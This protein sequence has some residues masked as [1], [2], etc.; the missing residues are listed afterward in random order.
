MN[1]AVE[2]AKKA[3]RSAS[4]NLVPGKDLFDP[5]WEA[6]LTSAGIKTAEIE[7][8]RDDWKLQWK[9]QVHRAEKAERRAQAAEAYIHELWAIRAGAAQNAPVPASPS[10]DGGG[11]P[12]DTEQT[13]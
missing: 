5:A 1:S 8:E 13:R 10:D 6:A 3:F 12:C 4:A 11:L 2:A 9:C 7:R